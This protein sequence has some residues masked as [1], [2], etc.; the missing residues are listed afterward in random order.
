ME[1]GTIRTPA[2]API[3]LS[4]RRPSGSPYALAGAITHGN[5][6]GRREPSS[7]GCS[8]VQRPIA[9]AVPAGAGGR[10]SATRAYG[11]CRTGGTSE[12]PVLCAFEEFTT[13]SERRVQPGRSGHR[14]GAALAGAALDGRCRA[15]L[16]RLETWFRNLVLTERVPVTRDGLRYVVEPFLAGVPDEL[17]PAAA[18]KLIA[19]LVEIYS[20]HGPGTP[21]W[22]VETA[23]RVR[24]QS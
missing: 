5:I 22:L 15:T 1:V 8:R 4:C 20:K 6:R 12:P 16:A 23:Y 10:T 24:G 7:V 11:L 13:R 2:H 9:P 3:R 14:R 17:R 21:A 18:D 19:A